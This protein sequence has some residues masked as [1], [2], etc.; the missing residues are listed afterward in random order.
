MEKTS[1]ALAK[2][3]A[4]RRA[5][6]AA[7]TIRDHRN[8]R[9]QGGIQPLDAGKRNFRELN[10]GDFLLTQQARGLLDRKKCQLGFSAQGHAFGLENFFCPSKVAGGAQVGDQEHH[11][12]LILIAD[13]AER[14]P[15]VFHAHA[16][17]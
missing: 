12:E 15:P 5:R 11:A 9:V 7:G 3:L 17:A 1:R 10:R 13:V 6:L 4:L 16:A 8:K 2:N 14:K